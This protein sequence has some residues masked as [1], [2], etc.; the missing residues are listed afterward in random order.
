MGTHGS[1]DDLQ[2]I[3]KFV[4]TRVQLVRP[5]SMLLYAMHFYL[6]T[7]ILYNVNYINFILLVLSVDNVNRTYSFP[8]D[9]HSRY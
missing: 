8:S 2:L 6:Y 3:C 5:T 1:V 9:N 7:V 4:P